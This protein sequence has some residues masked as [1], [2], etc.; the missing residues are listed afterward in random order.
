MPVDDVASALGL[1]ESDFAPSVW[2]P[3]IYNG[4]RYG[5]PLDVHCLA[6]YYNK[7]HFSQPCVSG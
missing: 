2:P 7:D 3:G 1:Q 4:K 6:M 5:I